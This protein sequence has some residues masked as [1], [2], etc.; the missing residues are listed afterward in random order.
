MTFKEEFMRKKVLAVC[1][2]VLGVV[3]LFSGEVSDPDPSRRIRLKKAPKMVYDSYYGYRFRTGRWKVKYK[4]KL[5]RKY[6]RKGHLIRE[7]AL[8]LGFPGT[9]RLVN[10]KHMSY[11]RKGQKIKTRFFKKGRLLSRFVIS[12]NRRGQQSLVKI[13]RNGRRTGV[14]TMKYKWTRKGQP[15]EQRL[16]YNKKLIR[17]TSNAYSPGGFKVKSYQYDGKR[18]LSSVR[19]YDINGNVIKETKYFYYFKP[20]STNRIVYRYDR[21]GNLVEKIIYNAQGRLSTKNVYRN[22]Y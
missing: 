5:W 1:L 4:N 8:F 10:S 9:G 18:R 21:F 12:Y 6:N 13:Y 11:N 17:R 3:P 7:N 2:A 16:Y 15:R 22:V 14:L 20:G 19:T